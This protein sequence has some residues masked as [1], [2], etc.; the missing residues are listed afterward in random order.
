MSVHFASILVAG[1]IPIGYRYDALRQSEN[2][3]CVPLEG[4]ELACKDYRHVLQ[5]LERFL[6]PRED[7][8]PLVFAKVRMNNG[9]KIFPLHY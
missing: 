7:E 3:H 1:P 2:S 8:V 6:T 4:F 5:S 9:I